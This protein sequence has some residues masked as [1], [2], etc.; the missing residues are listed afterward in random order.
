[1]KT[2]SF[3]SYLC[4]NS[5]FEAAGEKLKLLLVYDIYFL[6]FITISWVL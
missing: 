6:V 1:M 3:H 2:Q 4:V 5:E